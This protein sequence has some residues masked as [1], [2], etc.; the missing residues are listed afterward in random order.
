MLFLLKMQKAK[1]GLMQDLLSGRVRVPTDPAPTQE[2]P[3]AS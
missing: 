1:S 3:H 2:P